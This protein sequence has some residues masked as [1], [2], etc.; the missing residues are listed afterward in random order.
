MQ[1]QIQN[2]QPHLFEINNKTKRIIQK[3]VKPVTVP[4]TSFHHLNAKTLMDIFA[5]M[6]ALDIVNMAQTNVRL[7]KKVNAIFG[8]GGTVVLSPRG[9]DSE[10]KSATGDDDDDYDD[11]AILI[12]DE[13]QAMSSNAPVVTMIK[14]GDDEIESQ[15]QA[16]SQETN[17]N[18]NV[19]VNININI[20]ADT[21]SNLEGSVSTLASGTGTAEESVVDHLQLR[22]RRV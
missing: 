9:N 3:K 12:V 15:A 5:L 22:L 18:V 19:N 7:Y 6:D 14:D 4:V 17:M 16:P 10:I 13:V 1:M 11:E 2:K 8:L 20:F 21:N